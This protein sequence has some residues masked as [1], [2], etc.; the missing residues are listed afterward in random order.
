MSLCLFQL[1]VAGI[2]SGLYAL[3]M[4]L[5]TVGL[6]L[7]MKREGYCAP[8]T[9][10]MIFVVGVFIISA[11]MHPMEFTCLLHG[12]LYFMSIPSMSMLLMIYSICNLHV[13]SWGTREVMQPT[14]AEQAKK[15][16]KKLKS[17]RFQS[18]INLF[19]NDDKVQ[20]DVI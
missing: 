5:V 16:Q 20:V 1:K 7:E 19:S 6:A 3:V 2:L 10:F 18:I 8:T 14:Q 15:E 11:I 12:A 17:G 9:I 13:V 4:M